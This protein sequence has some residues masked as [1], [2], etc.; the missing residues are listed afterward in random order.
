M[1]PIYSKLS[2][3]FNS[4]YMRKISSAF[5]WQNLASVGGGSHVAYGNWKAEVTPISPGKGCPTSRPIGFPEIELY[6]HCA[7]DDSSESGSW[8]LSSDSCS[9]DISGGYSGHADYM[10][11]CGIAPHSLR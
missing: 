10:I 5:G 11:A 2:A 3:G 6:V 4:Y 9:S 1:S 7:V 8:R